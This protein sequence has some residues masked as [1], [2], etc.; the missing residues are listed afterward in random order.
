MP[1]NSKQAAHA[2]GGGIGANVVRRDAVLRDLSE[3]VAVLLERTAV[4]PG[5]QAQT[6]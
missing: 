3:S 4:A 6:E 2:R 1:G 5:A